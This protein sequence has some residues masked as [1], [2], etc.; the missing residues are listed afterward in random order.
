MIKLQ[1]GY[2]C[3]DCPCFNGDRYLCNI[4]GDDVKRDYHS[5]WECATPVADCPMDRIVLTK[6]GPV[7]W[8]PTQIMGIFDEDEYDQWLDQGGDD[9]H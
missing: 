3:D 2:H 5:C 4:T 9:D 1:P 6:A 7:N 8:R